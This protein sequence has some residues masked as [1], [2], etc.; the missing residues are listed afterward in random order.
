MERAIALSVDHRINR[1]DLPVS[2]L[3]QTEPTSQESTQEVRTLEE[4]ERQYI[5]QLLQQSEGNYSEVAEKL[6]IGR[7][8]LW[9]KMKKYGLEQEE[10]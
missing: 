8:T 5:H 9:R 7:T 4:V 10:N 1:D 6:G 3:Q 2:V